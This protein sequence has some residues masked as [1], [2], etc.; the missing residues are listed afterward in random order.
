MLGAVS[1]AP[2]LFQK[3]PHFN[4]SN[5]PKAKCNKAARRRG[6]CV[7][8]WEECGRAVSSGSTWIPAPQTGRP[9]GGEGSDG[10]A[11]GE[12][13]AGKREECWSL[14]SERQPE[15]SA[16]MSSAPTLIP[17]HR[18]SGLMASFYHRRC[19][20]RCALRALSGSDS[21]FCALKEVLTLQGENS[22][23]G[24]AV[25]PMARAEGGASL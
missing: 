6:E 11:S 20:A 24:E 12:V 7:R 23:H 16:T 15:V 25:A 14:R 8:A 2:D 9:V 18:A 1:G 4:P 22:V 5:S 19:W 3:N 21:Q 17:A 10:G 13:S